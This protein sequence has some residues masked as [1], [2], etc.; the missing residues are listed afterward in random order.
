MN[1]Q[2][3]PYGVPGQPDTTASKPRIDPDQ[4]PS[5]VRERERDQEAFVTAN[6]HTSS[7]SIPPSSTTKYCAIDEGNLGIK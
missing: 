4:I 2:T 5:V 1:A 3:Q 7:R 6:F